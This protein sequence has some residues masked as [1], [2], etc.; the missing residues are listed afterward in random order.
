MSL[1]RFLASSSQ[2]L[3]LVEE[4]YPFQ[5]TLVAL[6]QTNICSHGS[7]RGPNPGMIVLVKSSSKLL[8]C[9]DFFSFYSANTYSIISIVHGLI[10]MSVI[11]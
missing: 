7:Q 5:N 10:Q 3:P 2:T 1:L 4:D 9:I 6:E 8:L 11:V